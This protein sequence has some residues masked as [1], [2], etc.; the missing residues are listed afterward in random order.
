MTSGSSTTALLGSGTATMVL[1]WDDD[2]YSLEASASL[3]DGTFTYDATF[4]FDDG[5]NILLSA[6]ANVNVPAR[7]PAD[8]RPATWAAR[9]SCS[10]I[11]Q[12]STSG[13]QAEG[14]IAAWTSIDLLVTHVQ[15][16][17]EYNYE[18]DSV[19]TI[20]SGTINNLKKQT[21]SASN[22][23]TYSQ[24][25][26]VPDGAT[27]GTLEVDWTGNSVL[28]ALT[29]VLT[30]GGT[31]IDERHRDDDHD[32]RHHPAPEHRLDELDPA[33]RGPRGL[34]NE[35]VRGARGDP[36]RQLHAPGDVYQ[37]RRSHGHVHRDLRLITDDS[38][39]G[40][41]LVTFAGGSVPSDIEVGDTVSIAG[42]GVSSYD[43]TSS[44]PDPMVRRSRARAWSST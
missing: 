31:G 15:I 29:P 13:G 17:I 40:G 37:R 4:Q 3:L 36:R 7:H 14:F 26:T 11:E 16:G 2:D 24:S 44:T 39:D 38:A 30:V 25:F 18:K 5:N 32:R 41:V 10:S 8:R 9:R 23:Y 20:G 34:D 6:T 27:Q 1:D 42:T 43:T 28:A 35:P 22:T 21:N 19:E 12:P 33:D